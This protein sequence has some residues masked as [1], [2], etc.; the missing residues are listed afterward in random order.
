MK[1][2]IL[3]CFISLLVICLVVSPKEA[4]A[5]SGKPLPTQKSNMNDQQ[6]NG[7]RLFVQSCALCHLPKRAKAG[8]LHSFGPS[9]SGLLKGANAE[10]EKSIRETILKGS[11][12]MP[13]FQYGI[14]AKDID[15]LMAYL[16]T[17]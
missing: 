15:N 13:G 12:N 1:I 7:E 3:V 16:K 11:P 6:K 5:Q 10:R 14:E 17:L 2:N 9:L 8:T 4:S